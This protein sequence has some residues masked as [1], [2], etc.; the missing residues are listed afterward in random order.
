MEELGV[1]DIDDVTRQLE[2]AAKANG[3][4]EQFAQ[5][6]QSLITALKPQAEVAPVPTLAAGKKL[7]AQPQV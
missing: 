2:A 4:N 1:S 6:L 3:S 5:L 7:Q